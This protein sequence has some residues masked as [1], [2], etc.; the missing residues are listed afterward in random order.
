MDRNIS[1]K[2]RKI[3]YDGSVLQCCPGT[4]LEI[5]IWG[6]GSLTSSCCRNLARG[7]RSTRK[8]RVGKCSSTEI[9][10]AG[11]CAEED[12]ATEK[13]IE[14]GV[15]VERSLRLTV[16]FFFHEVKNRGICPAKDSGL[17]KIAAEEWP[18]LLAREPRALDCGRDWVCPAGSW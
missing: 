16:F 17:P 8:P 3:K 18:L 10:I 12:S 15:G 2:G 11:I 9:G 6:P 7:A 5:A 1:P 14:D 13:G 4:S